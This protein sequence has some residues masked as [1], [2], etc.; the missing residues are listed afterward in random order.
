MKK[1]FLLYTVLLVFLFSACGYL[2]NKDNPEEILE[3][4]KSLDSYSCAVTIET[5]ND[6]QNLISQG[7]QLYEKTIGYRFEL[8]QDRVMIYE[9][10]KIHVKDLKNGMKYSTDK[11][12]DFLYKLSFVGEYINLLYTNQDIKSSF[13]NIEGERLLVIQLIIPGNNQNLERADLYIKVKNN[14]PKFLYV[15]DNKNNEKV[16]VVYDEFKQNV[17]VNKEDFKLD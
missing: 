8:G 15:Y 5:K 6:K 3:A 14:E 10:D 17:D 2:K 4:L 16:K 1:L 9:N 12:F 11:D 13:K 7:K